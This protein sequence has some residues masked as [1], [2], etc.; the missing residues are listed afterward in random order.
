[1]YMLNILTILNAKFFAELLRVTETLR[2]FANVN[3]KHCKGNAK[4]NDDK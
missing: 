3:G 4:I 1:M 2:I